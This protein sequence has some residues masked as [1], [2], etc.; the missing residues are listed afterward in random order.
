MADKLSM[1][2]L[3]LARRDKTGVRLLA[4]VQGKETLSTR[5][6][7]INTLGLPSSWASQISKIVYDSR[8]YWELWIETADSWDALRNI[9]KTRGYTNVPIKGTPEYSES[10]TLTP[11]VNLNSLPKKSLMIRK[12]T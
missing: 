6:D 3:Y 12:N 10:I 8:M 7:D 5:V 2:Y 1:L 11:V 9:L 4:I